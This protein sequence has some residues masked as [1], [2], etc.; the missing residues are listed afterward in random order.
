MI[1][2]LNTELVSVRDGQIQAGRGRVKFAAFAP[3]CT[4]WFI[5]YDSQLC[6]WGPARDTFPS[7]W[8]SLISELEQ[9]H[10]RKD[11]CVD[12]VAFGLHDLLL[13]RFENGNSLMWLPDN[14]AMR[15]RISGGLI[16]EVE[17]RLASGWTFGNRTTLCTFDA[18]R[19]FL[20]WKKVSAAVFSYSMGVDQQDD[21][22]RVKAV[23]SGVGN[24]AAAV[25]RAE[26]GQL[27]SR[28]RC[29]EKALLL[30]F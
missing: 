14:P 12:F 6:L 13:V 15:A 20:E 2:H 4:S 19:W 21:L 9:T 26:T 3:N 7:T 16:K 17:E 27:V 8:Q 28:I 29:I 11:E 24:D 1:S 30:K 23:L 18:E 5:R 22:A 10:S 25:A